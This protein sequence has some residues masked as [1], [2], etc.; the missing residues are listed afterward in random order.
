MLHL[1]ND[2]T[3]HSVFSVNSVLMNMHVVQS[4]QLP[5]A[6]ETWQDEMWQLSSASRIKFMCGE[7]LVTRLMLCAG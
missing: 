1:R 7:H 2:M 5:V 4:L 6:T 3:L